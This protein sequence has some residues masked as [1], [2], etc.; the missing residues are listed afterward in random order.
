[1]FINEVNQVNSAGVL[2][3]LTGDGRLVSVRDVELMMRHLDRGPVN[4]TLDLISLFLGLFVW[5]SLFLGEIFI[6]VD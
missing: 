4:L 1:M 6:D 3:N 2:V 5:I